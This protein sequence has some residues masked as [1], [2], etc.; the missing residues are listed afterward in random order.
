[1]RTKILLIIIALLS[2][3]KSYTQTYEPIVDTTKMWVVYEYGSQK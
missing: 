3:T 1:M 2:I